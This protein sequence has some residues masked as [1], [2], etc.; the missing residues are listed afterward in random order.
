MS[1]LQIMPLHEACAK[2]NVASEYIKTSLIKVFARTFFDEEVRSEEERSEE[3][4]SDDLRMGGWNI[5]RE[6][7]YLTL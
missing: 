5:L 4:R 7:I 2:T 6:D 3:E 1:S